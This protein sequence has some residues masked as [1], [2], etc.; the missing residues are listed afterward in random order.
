MNT[1]VKNLLASV[2]LLALAVLTAPAQQSTAGFQYPVPPEDVLDLNE[3]ST[4][5]IEHFWDR[6]NPKSLFSNTKNF[7][8]AFSQFV[9]VMP[10]ADTTV[11][12]KSIEHLIKEVKK[13]STNLQT[14]ARMARAKLYSDTAEYFLDA[15]Y[16]P[17]AKAAVNSSGLDKE[18]KE[19]YAREISQLSHSQIGMVAPDIKMTT[20][21]GSKLSLSDVS[22][23]YV[24]I[25]FDDP[26]DFNNRLARTR[27]ATD[28]ALN[29][30]IERGYLKVISLYPGQPDAEWHE[31]AAS[32]PENW[33]VAASPEADMMF[34]RRWT[35]TCYYLNRDHVIMSKSLLPENLIEGFRSAY[36]R[37][38]QNDAERE[39]LRREAQNQM[40]NSTGKQ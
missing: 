21:D 26:E 11:V 16:L 1:P 25:F 38:L 12:Q 20:S 14:M 6:S 35:P 9:A 4:Y 29:G 28:Y 7:D 22:N 15:A 39:R 8:T 23:S 37:Q 40:I 19:Q 34:D 2:M 17:F 13:N 31:R 18:E 5:I 32:Y 3:R 33:I 27:L 10:Y 30:L 36:N 24:L